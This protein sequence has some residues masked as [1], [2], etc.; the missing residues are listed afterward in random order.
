MASEFESQQYR[1]TAGPG[2]AP[3]EP[4]L[5]HDIGRDFVRNSRRVAAKTVVNGSVD[6]VCQWI[7]RSDWYWTGQLKGR[8]H[9]YEGATAIADLFRTQ[10]IDGQALMAFLDGGREELRQ[11]GMTM[12]NATKMMSSLRDLKKDAADPGLEQMSA[13][14]A[15]ID[16][17][18]LDTYG[19]ASA[20]TLINFD[21]EIARLENIIVMKEHLVTKVLAMFATAVYL[22]GQFA[23]AD[24]VSDF[25]SLGNSTIFGR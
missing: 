19:R 15:S 16:H 6:D 10:E 13:A 2:G 20:E 25:H 12:G 11:L 3:A 14:I 5:G 1:G 24:W 7:Q 21:V 8:Q 22:I 18:R 17:D 4:G 23:F 9:T